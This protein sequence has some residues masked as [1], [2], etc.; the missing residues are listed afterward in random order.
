MLNLNFNIIG[1][2]SFEQG[3]GDGFNDFPVQL[4]L[5]GGGGAGGAG[6]TTDPGSG[7]GAG[8][9]ISASWTAPALTTFDVIIGAGGVG[10]N[11]SGSGTSGEDSKLVL[12]SNSQVVFN[13]IGGGRGADGQNSGLT[14]GS[15][16]G[17]GVVAGIATNVTPCIVPSNA[18]LAATTGSRGGVPATDVGGSGGGGAAG[19]GGNPTNVIIDA[20]GG[21]GFPSATSI[22]SGSS[23][24]GTIGEG[25]KGKANNNAGGGTSAIANTG[26]GGQG[27]A[28]GSTAGSGGSGIFAI[29]YAGLPKATGGTITQSGGFTTHLFLSSSQLV[30]SGRTH[31]NP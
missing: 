15:S 12:A 17:T 31:S 20:A 28:A 9:F 29:R 26:N 6:I 4:L 21:A 19:A 7:G 16:G 24:S 23:A 10:S 3:R 1:S 22:V 11:V 30:V 14:G 25:G 5:I 18:I 8:G 2:K 27:A 13:A